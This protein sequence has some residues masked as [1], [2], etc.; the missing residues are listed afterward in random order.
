MN[1]GFLDQHFLEDEI[2]LQIE[3][4]PVSSYPSVH[5]MDNQTACVFK[6]S[7]W[8]DAPGDAGNCRA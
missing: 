2:V 6:C 4:E 8:H 3:K 5:H 7:P 1:P